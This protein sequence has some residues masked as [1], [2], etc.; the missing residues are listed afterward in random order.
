MET[1]RKWSYNYMTFELRSK[2]EKTPSL[3]LLVSHPLPALLVSFFQLW[4]C[5]LY[6]LFFYDTNRAEE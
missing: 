6:R 2:E 5:N 1:L 3:F 4:K